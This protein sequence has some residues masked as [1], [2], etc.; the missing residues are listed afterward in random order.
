MDAGR[1]D[2]DVMTAEDGSQAF[3]GEA[4]GARVAAIL[5]AANTDAAAITGGA[6]RAAHE[7]LAAA[8]EE[9]R[10][11]FRMAA[12]AALA[13][14]RERAETLAALRHSIAD[15]S[16]SLIAE[17]DDPAHVRDQVESLLV[18]LSE[19]E[20]LLVAGGGVREP[21]LPEGLEEVAGRRPQVAGVEPEP[22]SPAAEASRPP[23]PIAEP[24]A[25]DPSPATSDQR[26]AT[27]FSR[28]THNRHDGQ[29]LALLRMAVAGVTR[30]ELE[31]E[32]DPALPPEEREALLDDV[33]GAPEKARQH[34]DGNGRNGR[35]AATQST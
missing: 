19:T 32:L 2:K 21:A 7:R 17:A 5:D 8:H 1:G 24:E 6:E 33:F 18:A 35:T 30:T 4:V 9:A 25:R 27:P 3:H 22:A 12:D 23:E 15:R 20:A 13:V 14:A 10:D 28:W 11:A 31:R 29:V 34:A 16:E 26:P